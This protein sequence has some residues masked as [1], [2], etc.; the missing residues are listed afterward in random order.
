MKTYRTSFLSVAAFL[1][2]LCSAFTVSRTATA[3]VV[4][5]S[6][7]TSFTAAPGE[8]QTLTWFAIDEVGGGAFGASAN[9]TAGSDVFSVDQTDIKSMSDTATFTITFKPDLNATGIFKG[10]LTCDCGKTY[11]LIGMVAEAGVTSS[12]PSNVSFS[13]SWNPAT[14]NITIMSSGVRTAEIGIYDLLGN[15]IASSNATTWAWDASSIATGSYFVRITGES[16]SGEQFAI[17][18]RIIIAR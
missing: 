15:P 2:L 5:F 9:I 11:E 14:D 8:S 10:T 3:C 4:S 1:M 12:L 6:G 7:P 13:I 18:R 17:W 16:N